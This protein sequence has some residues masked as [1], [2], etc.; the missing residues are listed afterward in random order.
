MSMHQF[1]NL[2]VTRMPTRQSSKCFDDGRFRWYVLIQ[3]VCGQHAGRF[4]KLRIIQKNQGLI[5]CDGGFTTSNTDYSV[6]KS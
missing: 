1:L 6:L 4:H 3:D 5:W 2:L